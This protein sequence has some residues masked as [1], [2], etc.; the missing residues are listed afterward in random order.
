[1][2]V[3]PDNSVRFPETARLMVLDPA[4]GPIERA[5]SALALGDEVLVVAEGRMCFRRLM[6]LQDTVAPDQVV[7]MAPGTL[8]PDM[9]RSM[10]QLDSR[11]VV[12]A[13]TP[14]AMAGPCAQ[15]SE[16]AAVGE[17][18]FWVQVIVEGAQRIISSNVAILTGPL[19]EPKVAP[20]GSVGQVFDVAVNS[21]AVSLFDDPKIVC[22]FSGPQQLDLVSATVDGKLAVLRFALP[23]RTTT[24][25]LASP[26]AQPPGDGRR[27]GVAVVKLQV[28]SIGIPLDSPA[29][30]R[31]F[32]RAEAGEGLTWRWTDGEALLILP[33]KPVPQ[34]FSVHITDWHKML[35]PHHAE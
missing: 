5:I 4:V 17:N 22:A 33:P 35:R 11:Q 23:P 1:M 2:T 3:M 30:V 10:L 14:A 16:P 29:L 31:G 6:A 26:N 21:E 25:R 18:N 19:P 8:G 13:P 20:T 34:T 12:S 24:L 32:H 7:W 15:F 28:D 27:L 9:P